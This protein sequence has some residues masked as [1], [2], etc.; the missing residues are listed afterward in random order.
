MPR[1]HGRGKKGHILAVAKFDDLLKIGFSR[2]RSTKPTAFF[3]PKKL[4]AEGWRGS[5]SISN[6]LKPEVAADAANDSVRKEILK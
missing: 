3:T 5:A 6:T 4:D 2:R 1:Q